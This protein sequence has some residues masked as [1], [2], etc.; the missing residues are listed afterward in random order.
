MAVGGPGPHEAAEDIEG[1]PPE[2]VGRAPAVRPFLLTAGRVSGRGAAAPI[3]IETQIVATSAGLSV[4]GTLAF[5]HHDIVAACRR[6]QS[7]AELAAC[8]RLHLNVVRVLAEDLCA[9]GHLAVHVPNA[10]T[11]QDISVLRRVINGLRA[12]PDSRGTLRDSG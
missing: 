6:P 9:A 2:P 4:L 10:R 11:A 1:G 3:P 5:E 12:V 7:V 8:L